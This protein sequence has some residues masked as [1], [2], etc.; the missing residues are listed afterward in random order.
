MKYYSTRFEDYVIEV[1]K[2]NLHPDIT[3]KLLN[4]KP[5]SD[6][7]I[8]GPP[9]TGKY[10]QVL[11]YIKNF[12]PTQLKF[13]RKMNFNFNN[14]KQHFF[15][16]SDIHIEIDFSLLGC[17]AKVLFNEL[18][19]QILDIFSTKI[20]KRGIVLCKNFHNIHN[21]LLENFY[22]YMQNIK[23]KNIKLSY[24]LMTEQI[25]FIP[26]NIINKCNIINITRPSKSKYQR[27]IRKN[28]TKDIKIENIKNIKNL[29]SNITIL[30][31]VEKKISDKIIDKIVNYNEINFMGFREILYETLTYNLNINECILYILT[32]FINNN[33][34]EKDKMENIYIKLSKFLIFYNNNYRPIYHLESFFYYLC[35]VIH[36]L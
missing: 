11:N 18:Y 33:M 30:N 10:S 25:S 13:E 23:H 15:K 35:K 34:L 29:K 9:G 1:E 6:I 27:C 28:I 36:G 32:Y 16:I 3:K 4:L 17:N 8:Y 7:I 19:Y 20:E 26:I 24:I 14:K 21:E 22:S 31:N 5:F 12:S 2:Y